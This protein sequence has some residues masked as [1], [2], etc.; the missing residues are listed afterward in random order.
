MSYTDPLGLFRIPTTSP[1]TASN[2]LTCGVGDNCKAIC[3]NA[4]KHWA[5]VIICAVCY[6][7]DRRPPPPPP[8]P[9]QSEV[10]RPTIPDKK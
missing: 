2:D 3:S 1:E 6:L 7:N 4:K 5:Q 10:P 8:K 9:P